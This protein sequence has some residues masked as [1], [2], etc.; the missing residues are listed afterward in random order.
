[1][2]A[3]D[4]FTVMGR[5]VEVITEAIAGVEDWSAP[6]EI[7]GQYRIDVV[8]DKSALEVLLDAGLGVLSEE[9]GVTASDRELLAVI[10]PIDG[11][12]NAARGIP[13]YA[14]S[15]CI[16]DAEGLLAAVVVNLADGTRYEAARGGGA[17]R[18]GEAIAATKTEKLA[19]AIVGISGLPPRP[20][21]WRQA[22]AFGAA[23]L[24][25]CAVADGRLDGFCEWGRRSLGAWDYLGGV[26][27]AAEAGAS[28]TDA[29]DRDLVVRRHGERR[30]PV[31]AATATLLDELVLARR[32]VAG[33]KE[34]A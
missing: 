8:A 34:A 23:A 14:T 18:G 17:T 29:F 9:S 21:R 28:C 32:S 30:S 26:L 33:P 11:S 10:D 1:M 6:G 3:R 5:A 19:D 31:V 24:E 27:V 4:L 22:R 25:I 20:V 15:I 13:W 7:D 12:T 2:H 16:I